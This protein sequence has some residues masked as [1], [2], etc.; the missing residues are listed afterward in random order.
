LLFEDEAINS[1]IS[2]PVVK[3]PKK[4]NSLVD[5]LREYYFVL[6]ADSLPAHLAEFFILPIFVIGPRPNKYWLPQSSFEHNSC[7]VFDDLRPLRDWISR[8]V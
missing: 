7:A 6:S 5:K 3:I 1:E 8:F 4:F 2:C